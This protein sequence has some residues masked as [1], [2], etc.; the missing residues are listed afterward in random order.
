MK[1]YLHLSAFLCEQCSGP[2]VMG[3]TAVR[4]SPMTR[5]TELREAGAVCL[6]CGHRQVKATQP[7]IIRYFPPVEWE[8]PAEMVPGPCSS[9]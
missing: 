3:F 6:S 1:K 8:S 2:V 7:D 9:I 4:E 5:E